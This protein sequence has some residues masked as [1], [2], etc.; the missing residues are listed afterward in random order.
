MLVPCVSSA[1]VYNIDQ[2]RDTVQRGSVSFA[3][4]VRGEVGVVTGIEIRVSIAHERTRDLQVSLVS[5]VLAEE[6]GSGAHFQDTMLSMEAS[7]PIIGSSGTDNPFRSSE[8]GGISYRPM[9]NL[10][11]YYG[12]DPNQFWFISV[13]DVG[14]DAT[15]RVLKQGD[16]APWGTAIGTQLILH[17][18]VPE[19]ST[20]VAV[21]LMC[22]TLVFK[23]IK[24]RK[25]HSAG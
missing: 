8:W 17:T 11:P 7:G 9:G 24:S 13:A 4:D 18:T 15:G 19:P 10:F 20:L 16:A 14:S 25:P 21:G 1:G 12:I 6:V 5:E 22:L 23:G 3:F 2:A